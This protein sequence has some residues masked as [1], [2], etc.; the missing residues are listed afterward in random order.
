MKYLPQ[1]MYATTAI[2][3]TLVLTVPGFARKKRPEPPSSVLTILILK[4]DNGQPLRNAAV[5]LHPVNDKDKQGNG[6][7]ELKTDAEGKASYEGL[8]YGKL[9]IQVLAKGFQT[10]GQ[11]YD[12]SQPTTDLTIKMER[13]AGQYSIY[14][15]HPS[16]KP[17][18]NPKPPPQ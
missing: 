9:R 8:P 4:G 12:I 7:L 15:D 1:G 6:G 13:P 14:E 10:Y 5:V 11:D 3:V 17:P 16:D 18:E 2:V